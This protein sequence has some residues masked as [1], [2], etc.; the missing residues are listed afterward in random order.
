MRPIGGLLWVSSGFV[1]FADG[2][3]DGQKAMAVVAGALVARGSLTGG[4]IPMWVRAAV[5]F[6]LALGTLLGARVLRT[7]SRRLYATRGLDAAMA[8]SSSAIVII[9]SSVVGAPVST[10]AVVTSGVVG[11]G[12]V[13][14]PRHIHW[15][16]VK[17]IAIVWAVS[18]PVSLAAGALVYSVL[19][20]V[21]RRQAREADDM[22]SL[23]L[24]WFLS[25]DP[26]LL[27]LLG[28]QMTETVVGMRAFARWSASGDEADAQAVRHAE[29]AADRARRALA[30]GVQKVLVPPL[31]PEDL[32]TMSERLDVVMNRAKSVVRDSQA[33]DWHPDAAAASMA[34]ALLEGTEHLA[35]AVSC[36]RGDAA[37][38]NTCADK[39]IHCVRTAEKA[40][41]AAMVALRDAH[42]DDALILI[43]TYEAYRSYLAIGEAIVHVSHRIWY[44]VLRAT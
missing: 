12:V 6:T 11:V 19:D 36:V 24:P 27:E 32:Y 21:A 39:A 42:I 28:N 30:E 7:V 10:T 18:F 23:R 40:H 25:G 38:A 41:R 44:S 34:A 9:A 33:V 29:H 2:S 26:D 37:K 14:H 17:R 3:N 5:G 1:G 16:V 20:A 4:G 43:T 15:S 31:E 13:Q 8:E 22:R 35:E